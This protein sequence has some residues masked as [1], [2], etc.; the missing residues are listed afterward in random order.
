MDPAAVKQYPLAQGRLSR[1]DVSRYADISQ[2]F[3]VHVIA[4]DVRMCPAAKNWAEMPFSLR[5]F[6]PVGF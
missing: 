5:H 3:E 1:V 2:S 4:M 6:P